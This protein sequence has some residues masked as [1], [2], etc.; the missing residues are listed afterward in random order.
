MHS[1]GISDTEYVKNFMHA[2]VAYEVFSRCNLN[3]DFCDER[4]AELLQENPYNLRGLFTSD[5]EAIGYLGD[6]ISKSAQGVFGVIRARIKE[7]ERDLS[8]NQKME[9]VRQIQK[10]KNAQVH[11]EDLPQ[12][13]VQQEIQEEKTEPESASEQ[14]RQTEVQP[15]VK[16]KPQEVAQSD[17]TEGIEKE[18][19]YQI[20]DGHLGEGGPKEK[21]HWNIQAIKTLH[22]IEQ[23]RRSATE[24]EKDILAKYVGWGG[25]SEAFDS[26]KVNW[27]QEYQEL[28]SV[29]TDEEYR[30]ARSSTL[31]AHYTSPMLIK[32]IYQALENMG[33]SGGNILEPSCGIGNFFGMMPESIKNEK[34]RL[35]G[36]E[37]DDV[38]GRIAKVLYPNANIQVNGF[39]NVKYPNNFFD[40]VV[41]NVPFGD[42]TVNDPAYNKHHFMIH[43]YFIAKGL[44]QLRPGGVMAVITSAGTMD[45]KNQDARKYFADRAEL[46]GAIR[47]PNTAFKAN[48]GTEVMTDILFF[49]KSDHADP[50]PKWCESKK[51]IGDDDPW[52]V[53][54]KV[55][56][57][58]RIWNRETR[59][60]ESKEFY[61][62]IAEIE[63][64]LMGTRRRTTGLK[65]LKQEK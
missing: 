36:V 6:E 58:E 42:Y 53:G 24:A 35:F 10:E 17:Q 54:D 30:A 41:G 4:N 21:Y 40:V 28:K 25:L 15:E 8:L 31:N 48:A 29:L 2:T 51:T 19:D 23:E 18:S 16:E 9:H 32:G 5:E 60:I 64:V 1:D 55:V 45:K 37:L 20:T 65:I 13:V 63:K 34:S 12:K 52:M 49:Q 44:D 39:E 22:T 56:Y 3:L 38:S 62:E 57:H 14:E 47:L 59:S 33:F 43:D 27:S 61:A 7:Y 46:L 11:Q 50:A 26:T